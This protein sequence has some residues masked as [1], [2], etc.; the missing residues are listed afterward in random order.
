MKNREIVLLTILAI[1][2][3][4]SG[5]GKNEEKNS[6]SEN[7]VTEVNEE[8]E[9]VLEIIAEDTTEDVAEDVTENAELT[10]RDTETEETEDIT[11]V[12]NASNSNVST[13][14][15]SQTENETNTDVTSN[16]PYPEY[17]DAE[18]C[19][20]SCPYCGCIAYEVETL[21]N[22]LNYHNDN[23]V[24]GS[25]PWNGDNY[26]DE[27]GKTMLW[28]ANPSVGHSGF[29]YTEYIPSQCG[30]CGADYTM[31]ETHVGGDS[32]YYG[33]AEKILQAHAAS[34]HGM[35]FDFVDYSSIPNELWDI[36][37]QQ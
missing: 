37:E 17:Y 6:N 21:E 13:G 24:C 9:R 10:Y 7:I 35:Y 28:V 27:R 25:Y 22:W 4:M 1:A 16:I 34:V 23:G 29:Y 8:T 32:T 14:I 15:N 26:V 20:W 19:T 11:E 3:M 12:K 18:Y 30:Y 36:A 31:Y 2:V 33:D 5:C